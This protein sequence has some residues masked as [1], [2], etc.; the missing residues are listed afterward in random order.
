MNT[1]IGMSELALRTDNI[2]KIK[3]FLSGID[4]AG[5]HLLSIINDI[6]DFSKIESGNLDITPTPYLFS[7]LLNDVVNVVRVRLV[8]KQIAFTVNVDGTLPNNLIGDESRVKQVLLNIL[9]NAVK[10]TPRGYIMF[11]ISGIF[12][13]RD[14]ILLSFEISDS[15]IGIRKDDLNNLFGDF[16][17]LDAKHNKGIEGTGLGLAI[18]RSLCQ[19]MGGEITVSSVYGEGS[20]F[21]AVIP[22]KFTGEEQLASVEDREKKG[23][24]FFDDRPHYAESVFITLQNLDV[25]VTVSIDEEEFCERLKSGEFKFAFVSQKIVGRVADLIK[26]LKL[27]TR[28]VLLSDLDENLSVNDSI[29][30]ITMPAYAV[31]IANTLNYISNNE[32][33]WEDNNWFIAPQA[34]ALIVDDTPTNLT[35][36]QGLLSPYQMQIDLCDSGEE[37]LMLAL[38]HHYDIIF[39]D[40]MMPGMD[41]IETTAKLRMI[42]RHEQTPIVALTA[43]AV[44]GMREMFLNNG[45][46]D[47]LSKPIDP[48][49]LDAVLNKW[50]PKWKRSEAVISAPKPDES[51]LSQVEGV[52]ITEALKRFSGDV[53]AYLNVVRAYV[54]HTPAMLKTL[55]SLEEK[56]LREYAIMVHG[57]KGSSYSICADIAG[58]MA[59]ELESAANA[60][61]SATVMAKNDD[62][63]ELAE[64]LIENLKP[65]LRDEAK[66]KQKKTSP[67]RDILAAILDSCRSYD[68]TAMSKSLSELERYDYGGAEDDLVKWLREQMENLEYDRIQ[69]RL[70]RELLKA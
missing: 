11:T 52:D 24:L 5:R 65:L 70:A 23:V 7:S 28:L 27:E 43:N 59:D 13:G 6:L 2:G 35:V 19:S 61:D 44:S 56:S 68:V 63:I 58:E 15:G 26:S 1:I 55:K 21:I 51:A 4:Q 8:K 46:N 9:S 14:E 20:V 34:R 41:G 38:K 67:D 10:Y 42:K 30:V 64:K 48:A 22:Q 54:T 33:R 49:R 36:A 60:G 12:T 16:V 40:H 17:R 45:M 50:I 57:I 53:E 69:E 31:P 3:D 66:A 37:A 62:F 32:N 39:M 25:P 47:F 29:Q 18:S